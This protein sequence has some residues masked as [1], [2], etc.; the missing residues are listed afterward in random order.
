MNNMLKYIV[1]QN[2]QQEFTFI[3]DDKSVSLSKITLH[4]NLEAYA[5][6]TVHIIIIDVSVQVTIQCTMQGS[7][8]QAK[9]YGAYKAS[10]NTAVTIKTMLHH[11]AAHTNSSLI[12]KGVVRDN[13][14]AHYDG[15][16]R[17]EKQA[18]ETYASQ[19][20]KNIILS[21]AARAVSIPNLE[22]LTNDVKC[23]HGSAV[24]RFDQDQIFYAACRGIDEKVAEKLLL[25]AFFDGVVQHND[26]KKRLCDE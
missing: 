10:G 23:F 26:M 8:A 12:V 21:N 22:V 6:L 20:N 16:I 15:I 9:I 4:F 17:I 3:F 13:A 19:E 2:Q 1:N 7:G 5:L 11:Q 14:H 25:Y 18:R 24:G